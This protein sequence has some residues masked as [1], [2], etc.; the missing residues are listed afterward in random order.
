MDRSMEAAHFLPFPWAGSVQSPKT[1]FTGQ[2]VR[3]N[4]MPNVTL[5]E[6]DIL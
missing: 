3:E 4:D 6:R 5:H 2:Q 1:H